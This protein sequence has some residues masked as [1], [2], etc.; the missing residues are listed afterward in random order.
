MK[1]SSQ[2]P[3]PLIIALAAG[4]SVTGCSSRR[5]YNECV[6]AAGRVISSADCRRGVPGAHWIRRTVQTGGFGGS[7]TSGGYYGG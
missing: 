3:A 6:D 5:S 1:R 4:L 7:G 2:V